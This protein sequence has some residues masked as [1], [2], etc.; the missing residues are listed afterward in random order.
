MKTIILNAASLEA[1]IDKATCIA[2]ILFVGICYA[3]YRYWTEL[4]KNKFND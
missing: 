3:F 4:D 2:V 1:E